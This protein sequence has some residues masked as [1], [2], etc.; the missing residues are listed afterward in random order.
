MALNQDSAKHMMFSAIWPY[1]VLLAILVGIAALPWFHFVDN[2][3]TASTR[4][5]TL[6]GLR[7]FL[8]FSVFVFHLIVTHEYIESGEWDPPRSRFYAL[9]GP[10][11]VSLFF[12][13]TGF[14]FWGKLLRE[15]GRPR[16]VELYLGRV[17]RIGPMYLFV[18]LVMLYIVFTRTGFT[19]HDPASEVAGSVLQW[20]ALGILNTEPDVNN[21]PASL[22]LAGVTWTISYE[23]V[24][25]ASLLVMAYFARV[26]THMLFV[27]TLLATG[28]AGKMLLGS[29]IFGMGAVFACGMAV[30]SMLHENWLPRMPR[31]LASTLALI[32]LTIIFLLLE[33]GYGADTLILLSIFFYLVCSGA[34]LFGLLTN[35]AAHRLGNISY[36]LYLMQGLVLTLVFSIS[37]IREFALQTELNFWIVGGV[38]ATVLVGAAA[39]SYALIERPGIVL[40]KRLIQRQ[41]LKMP[42]AKQKDGERNEFAR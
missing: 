36:S 3:S 34:S 21:Y 15:Q 16:W 20:L 2:P 5:A 7:G 26:K 23:W 29:F 31:A 33:N 13:I 27:L 42:I 18:V 25:Y 38:C 9:L 32:S 1:F 14:L 10:V 6:D 12:M 17:F 37:P 28:L 24:F 4:Y 40:G 22:V 19:L 41:R 30:A 39:L 8:A 35:V 11:G